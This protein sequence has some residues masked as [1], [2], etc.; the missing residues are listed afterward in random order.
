MEP[1][2]LLLNWLLELAYTKSL[3]ITASTLQVF[4]LNADL[5]K[6][7]FPSLG[8]L[9]SFKA[10]LEPFA[11]KP[12]GIVEFLIKNSPSAEVEIVDG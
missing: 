3:T 9:K 11:P 1:P 7:K 6:T 10:R 4:S 8:N 12:D 5:L 2:Q